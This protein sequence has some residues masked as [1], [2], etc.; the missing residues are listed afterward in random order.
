MQGCKVQSLGEACDPTNP[1]AR[2]Q[3]KN[4]KKKQFCTKNKQKNNKKNLNKDMK[5]STSK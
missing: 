1:V 3:D 2:N 4:K 5:Q